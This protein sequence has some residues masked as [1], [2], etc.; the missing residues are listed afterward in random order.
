MVDQVFHTDGAAAQEHRERVRPFAGAE[1]SLVVLPADK[2]LFE[3]VDA[4]QDFSASGCICQSLENR[5]YPAAEV[6]AHEQRIVALHRH[7]RSGW[8]VP[9]G[10][11]LLTQHVVGRHFNGGQ[12]CRLVAPGSLECGRVSILLLQPLPPSLVV[13]FA[14]VIEISTQAE[15]RD[16][17][18][19]R[20][21]HVADDLFAPGPRLAI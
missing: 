16:A 4:E 5:V 8:P 2:W 3:G 19:M 13:G 20:E 21:D 7:L 18:A 9:H 11:D 14:S 6:I 12:F 17:F 1:E 15:G 10:F